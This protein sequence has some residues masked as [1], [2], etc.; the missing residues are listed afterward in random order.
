LIAFVRQLIDRPRHLQVVF[1]TVSPEQIG[2][3]FS[4]ATICLRLRRCVIL[5]QLWD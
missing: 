1:A 4:C 3:N 5:G 2:V